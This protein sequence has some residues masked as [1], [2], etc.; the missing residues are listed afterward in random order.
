M[1][2]EKIGVFLSSKSEL[3]ESYKQAAISFGRFIGETGRT[4][5]YGGA[6]KGLMEELAASVKSSGGRVYGVVPEILERRGLVS[7]QI[8]VT[9]RCEDLNDRKAVMNRESDVLVALPGG[10][11]T[12]DE[13]FTVLAATGIGIRRQPVVFLNLDGCWSK[14]LSALDDLFERELISGVA[15]DYY[16]VVETVDELKQMLDGKQL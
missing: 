11:G 4:L 1:N 6:R 5:V 12:L 2:Y 15:S 8:D 3:P 7:E 16:V 10:I 9:F 13:V 14:L